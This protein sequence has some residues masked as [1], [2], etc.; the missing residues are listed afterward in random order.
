MLGR[1]RYAARSMESPAPLHSS[2]FVREADSLSQG[3]GGS[4]AQAWLRADF[5]GLSAAI[6]MVGL[7]LGTVLPLTALNL[8][9][10]GHSTGLIGGLLAAHAVG[11]MLALPLTSPAVSAWGAAR[12]LPWTSAAAAVACML[13]QHAQSPWAVGA[14]LAGLG[15]LL[16]VVFN[17]VETWL[18]EILPEASRGRWVAIHCTVFT[19]FQLSGPLL[20]Q[21][22]PAGHAYHACGLLLLLSL[23]AYR[24]L[25][26][27]TLGVQNHEA[28][29][30]TWWR[31][32]ALAPAVVWSTVLFALFDAVVLGILPLYARQLGLLEAQ[33]LMSVSV[34]LAGDA[35]LEWPV[36][37]LADRFG[38]AR[39]HRGCAVT[40]AVAALLLPWAVGHLA[41]W[42]LL[43]LLGGAAGG[44]YVLSLMA[45]GQRFKGRALL[46]MTSL[47]GAGWGAAGSAGPWLTGW[48]ME[49][50]GTWALPLVLFAV[51]AVLMVFLSLEKA[52]T[53]PLPSIP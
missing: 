20:L 30:R 42:P 33:A 44:I 28:M 25:R 1:N 47:L 5:V 21:V 13:L 51:A 35:A 48:L 27:R 11:L 19:L 50:N 26:P 53:D 18:N 17:L 40:L 12:V 22:L 43:F 46:Q 6:A 24:W 49:F 29:P 15:V 3:E 31:M 16:G 52:G 7:A 2:A 45:C 37:W 14:G 8:S 4:A 38:R 10:A 36:G 34:V 39:I 9:N 23:P 41:W 32:L